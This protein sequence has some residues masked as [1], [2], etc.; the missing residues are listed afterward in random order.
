MIFLYLL[1]KR[2]PIALLDTTLCAEG[3]AEPLWGETE[4]IRAIYTHCLSWQKITQA[5]SP[6]LKSVNTS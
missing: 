1:T 5:E 3:G 6:L 4:V 2:L